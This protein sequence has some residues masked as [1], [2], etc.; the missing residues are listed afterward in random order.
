MIISWGSQNHQTGGGGGGGRG[1][2]RSIMNWGFQFVSHEYIYVHFGNGFEIAMMYNFGWS[3]QEYQ[4]HLECTRRACAMFGNGSACWHSTTKY[5]RTNSYYRRRSFFPRN[6][7]TTATNENKKHS[8]LC[9]AARTHHVF[10][11]V[12]TYSHYRP[13]L[14]KNTFAGNSSNLAVIAFT[15]NLR[16]PTFDAFLGPRWAVSISRVF[17]S[18]W[19]WLGLPPCKLYY[20]S[21]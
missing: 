12:I 1:G 4:M 19:T 6:V 14:H 21:G 2:G 16:I 10:P 15:I 17:L 18:S 3:L 8:F 20:L 9:V 7:S 13:P 5:K 11:S